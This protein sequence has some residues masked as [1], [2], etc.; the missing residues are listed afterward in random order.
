MSTPYSVRM[1]TGTTTVDNT[2]TALGTVPAGKRWIVREWTFSQTGTGQC[3]GRL[4]AAGVNGNIDLT[5]LLPQH[6]QVART[7]RHVVLNAGDAINFR[8]QNS[9]LPII[10]S[11]TIYG[12][13]L[14]A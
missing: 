3:R 13:E 4:T 5:D 8:S 7:E 9:T 2:A 6:A 10:L 11:C 12:Y 14:D 1:G